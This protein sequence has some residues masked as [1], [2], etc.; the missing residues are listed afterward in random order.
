MQVVTRSEKQELYILFMYICL[1]R[2]VYKLCLVELTMRNNFSPRWFSSDH[3]NLHYDTYLRSMASN[4]GSCAITPK[5][6]EPNQWGALIAVLLE[7]NSFQ[8]RMKQGKNRPM[9][10]I[11]FENP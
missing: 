10:H 11:P 2:S 1:E 7:S 9:L 6:K 8:T 5:T 4:K 3:W